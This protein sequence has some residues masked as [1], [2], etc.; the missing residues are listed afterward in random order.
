MKYSQNCSLRPVDE[1][2]SKHRISEPP[3]A[4]HILANMTK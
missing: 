2:L 1:F 3:E 4:E